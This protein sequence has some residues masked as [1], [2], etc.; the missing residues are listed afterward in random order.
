MKTKKLK[1][2]ITG[3]TGLLASNIALYKRDKWEILLLTR[4][5]SL[6]FEGVAS[7]KANLL[8]L[9]S[10][11]RLLE[12]FNP[13]LVIHTAGLAN[14]EEC[15]ENYYVAHLANTVITKNIAQICSR[16]KY[17]LVHIS[18]DHFSN[19]ELGTSSELDIGLPL[20]VYAETKLL[21]ESAVHRFCDNAIIVRTN[22]FGWGHENRTSFSDF[23]INNLR[24]NSSI[25]LFDD[26]FYTPIFIDEL[27]DSINGLVEV[28]ATGV[29]NIVSNKKITKYEFGLK[30]AEVFT[31]DQNLIQK[32]SI[33]DKSL[34]K[35]PHNMALDNKKLVK[36]LG[37]EF[38][39]D[40]IGSIKKLKNVE[41]E[42]R[43]IRLI[44]S[45]KDTLSHKKE[46]IFYGKQFIQE[47]DVSNVVSTLT[48]PSLTQGPK[49]EEF[50]ESIA[51]Y[52]GS[53]YAVSF[54]NLTCGLHAAYLAA[55]IGPGDYV[56]TSPLTFVSTSN[57]AL[58]CNA[59]PLFADIDPKTLNID[60]AKVEELLKK[61][62]NKVKAIVAV[63]F[64]G[65]PCNMEQLNLVAKKYNV[66]VLEDSAHAL[67]GSYEDGDKIGSGKKSL[68]S[69]YSF[70]PVKNI[71]T[72]EGGV[73]TTNDSEVYKQM[74]R[75]R[76]HGIT[77]G[78]DPF[79]LKDLAFTDGK[80]NQWYYEMQSLGF[81]YRLTEIQCSLG[82]AQITK[83]DSLMAKRRA[84][85]ALYDE[86]L[87]KFPFIEVL[88][89]KTRHLSGNHLYTVKIDYKKI[90]LTRNEF[91]ARF[92]KHGVHLHVH[93]IPVFLQPFYKNIEGHDL[94]LKCQ[95]VLDYYDQAATLPL[96]PLLTEEKINF[97]INIFN[98]F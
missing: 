22:F 20:N 18:T 78:N 34:T 40:Y 17:K 10:T 12:N 7:V 80:K 33:A 47:D 51:N 36:T 28:N 45:I 13:D 42:G 89:E 92:I 6:T 90:G 66:I 52:A 62:G 49:V 74:C 41:F 39:F 61:F 87:K 44:E 9:D 82:L 83:L 43:N 77:K 32:G 37:A 27:V 48:G 16:K 58:F 64:A 25:T 60:P 88:Q 69:G 95:N 2:V 73:M 72:G 67:G 14:V 65:H 24:N 21:G 71:T 5:H 75:L 57:A 68:I 3:G 1:V 4:N 31:L 35:R 23:I 97:I 55:G 26:V 46:Q 19:Q 91:F 81:N 98:E 8:D 76:S 29:Y 59:I 86:G 38:N 79:S 94:A 56:I 53:K 93:Y 15:E 70:H 96:H 85:A 84:L 30:I 63:H 54:A 50:E 11:Q